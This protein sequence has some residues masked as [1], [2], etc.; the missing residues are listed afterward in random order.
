MQMINHGLSTGGLF[1]LVG[2]IYERYHTRQLDDLHG[3]ASRLPL[4]ACAMVFISMASIGLPGLN[5]FIGEILSLGGMFQ[6]HPI[7]AAIGALGLVLG[8]WYLLSML[9][10]VLFGPFVEPHH[11]E[12]NVGDLNLREALALAPIFV[13]CLWIGVRP[14]PLL[15]TIK[16][17]VD[18]VAALYE[19]AGDEWAARPPVAKE[20]PLAQE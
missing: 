4:L 10:T 7:Y 17:D 13:L 11:G 8:A 5:G 3:L 16:P 14:Q 20:T 1:L 18:R 15:D 9:Q 6:R 19:N 2:M 12:A